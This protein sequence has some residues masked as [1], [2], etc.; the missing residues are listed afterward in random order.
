[1][2]RGVDLDL[3]FFREFLA[4]ELD[5]LLV[6]RLASK[7]SLA[8]GCE[9]N[10]ETAAGCENRRGG[11][12]RANIDND[13][14]AVLRCPARRECVVLDWHSEVVRDGGRGRLVQELENL[15]ALCSLL[16]C[17]LECR[18]L[19]L[20]EIGR[21][22]DDGGVDLATQ[23]VGCEANEHREELGSNALG[24]EDLLALCGRDLVGGFAIRAGNEGSRVELGLER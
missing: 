5:E 18:D 24:G 4:E 9:R 23:E 10:V 7:P 3:G 8:D 19:R 11:R 13:N 17:F 21:D 12:S 6:E 1:M 2:V 14:V 20:G 16:D 15:D 22:A